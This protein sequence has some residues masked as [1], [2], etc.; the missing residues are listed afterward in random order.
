MKRIL[1]SLSIIGIAAGAVAGGTIA[2]FNDTETSTGNIFVAGNIDLTVDSLGS[3][4][5][6]E[7]IFDSD[8]PARDL[9]DEVF[10]EFDDI[11]PGD[12]GWRHLSLHARDN[13]SYACLLISNK[14]DDE[15][16]VVDPEFDAG[17]DALDSVP[18]GELS[19]ELELFAWEDL[20]PDGIYEPGLEE[21]LPVTPDSFFD[22]TY[23]TYADSLSTILPLAGFG[24]TRHIGLF[25]CAG[26][27]AVDA[28]GNLIKPGLSGSTLECDGAGMSDIAQTDSFTADMVVH[29]EQVRNNPDFLCSGI[30]L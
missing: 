17:D 19:E 6:N 27:I 22:I 10:F 30:S 12:F 13:S 8:F 4:Y 21:I 18:N 7:G 9:T 16:G 28:G 29:A 3:T 23:I 24:D 25:W 11:K 5:N 14:E 2:F 26:T 15:N 20:F 1:I